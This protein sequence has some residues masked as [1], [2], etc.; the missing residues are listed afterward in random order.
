MWCSHPWELEGQ[1]GV[2][3]GIWCR[4]PHTSQADP[5][6]LTANP[7]MSDETPQTLQV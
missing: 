6:D 1:E 4:G 3:L 7:W 2:L 5:T